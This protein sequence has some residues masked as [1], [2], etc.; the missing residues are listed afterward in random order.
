VGV[1]GVV[2]RAAGGLVLLVVVRDGGAAVAGAFAVAQ[3]LALA[4]G[5]LAVLGT[6]T[7]LVRF[8]PLLDQQGRVGGE[9]RLLRVALRR[10]ALAGSAATVALVVTTAVVADRVDGLRAADVRLL[11]WCAAASIPAAVAASVLA[12]WLRGHERF[13]AFAVVD[14]MAGPVAALVVVV[15]VALGDLPVGWFGLGLLAGAL[16][17]LAV[18]VVASLRLA[19]GRAGPVADAD[20]D[21]ERR[22]WH[23]ALPRAPNALLNVAF[24]RLDGVLVA[25]LASAAAAGAYQVA[26]RLAT[27]AAVVTAAVAPTVAPRLARRFADGDRRGVAELFS[28]AARL[29]AM[30]G[31]PLVALLF[32]AAPELVALFGSSVDDS[33]GYL[34]IILVAMVVD[35]ATGPLATTLLMGGRSRLTLFDTGVALGLT[36]ACNLV[37]IPLVGATGAALSW[38]VGTAT[39][40]LLAASQLRRFEG[41]A[42]PAPTWPIRCLAAVCLATGGL[43]LVP[44]A[45]ESGAVAVASACAAAAAATAAAVALVRRGRVV[46]ALQVAA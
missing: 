43:V 39:L 31:L 19:S 30:V 41:L 32:V 26:S 12:G 20:P 42:L 24:L 1:G 27:L 2:Q 23:F 21:L 29:Q 22:F 34:R 13:V 7:G 33:V 37:L 8:V 17:P 16:V 46:A 15:A 10:S 3:T 40:N 35:L 18:A 36:T 28:S 4:F 11:G 5:T 44:V 38:I 45:L 9:R 25:V 6:D 14:R